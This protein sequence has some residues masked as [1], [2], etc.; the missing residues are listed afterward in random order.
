M[1]DDLRRIIEKAG[2]IVDF[3]SYGEG[4]SD[5]WIEAAERRLGVEFPK[6]YRWWLKNYNGGEVCGEEI[7]SVYGIDFEEVVGGDIVYINELSRKNDPTFMDK[8]VISETDDEMF[9]FD[10]SNGLIENE[11][12]IYEF[13]SK[14]LYAPS[15]AEFLKKKIMDMEFGNEI[16]N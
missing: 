11:Y 10:L 12:P 8:L 7:Y 16:G 14:T 5:A 1:Y 6:S 2:D 4:V 15:F 9:Y 3:A 13:Y